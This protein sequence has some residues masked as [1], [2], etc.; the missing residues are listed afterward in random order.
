M[1]AR[2]RLAVGTHLPTIIF[3]VVV[4]IFSIVGTFRSSS[5]AIRPTAIR[6][7]PATPCPSGLNVSM[8]ASPPYVMCLHNPPELVSSHLLRAGY[9]EECEAYPL[10]MSDV[11]NRSGEVDSAN[12]VV[13]QHHGMGNRGR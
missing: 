7:N 5:T 8:H 9:W 10:I 4:G 11:L 12:T 2:L 1:L 6:L 13:H 3:L